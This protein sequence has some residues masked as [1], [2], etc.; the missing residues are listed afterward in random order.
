M[1]IKML[2]NNTEQRIIVAKMRIPKWV[3]GVTKDIEQKMNSLG[4]V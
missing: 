1:W 2:G 3:C 4:A